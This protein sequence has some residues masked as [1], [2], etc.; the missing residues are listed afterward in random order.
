MAA[1]NVKLKTDC[2]ANM[3]RPCLSVHALT[4]LW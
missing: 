3:F 2:L 4:K 1:H